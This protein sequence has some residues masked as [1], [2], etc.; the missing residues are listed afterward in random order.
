MGTPE[1]NGQNLGL[2][3]ETIDVER[4]R[5]AEGLAEEIRRQA[6]IGRMHGKFSPLIR[7]RNEAG[8][9]ERLDNGGINQNQ[10]EKEVLGALIAGSADGRTGYDS[11]RW[12]GNKLG[13]W[14][15]NH[16]YNWSWEADGEYFDSTEVEKRW[17]GLSERESRDYFELQPLQGENVGLSRIYYA[18]SQSAASAMETRRNIDQF[19]VVVPNQL[20][21]K[22]WEAV[23]T[24]PEL[25]LALVKTVYPGSGTSWTDKEILEAIKV[26]ELGNEL[27]DEKT[28]ALIRSASVIE[29][30][31]PL[32]GVYMVDG[33]RHNLAEVSDK[34]AFLREA[35]VPVPGVKAVEAPMATE[36]KLPEIKVDK[37]RLIDSRNRDEMQFLAAAAKLLSGYQEVGQLP[38]KIKEPGIE[39]EA[40]VIE[41]RNLREIVYHLEPE[42]QGKVLLAALGEEEQGSSLTEQFDRELDKLLLSW[43]VDLTKR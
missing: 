2:D 34:M 40:F 17:Y 30:R 10:T 1:K 42:L 38:E 29:R 16:G 41:M 12:F 27:P 39:R 26:W 22:I 21:G 4:Q 24:D 15:R 19:S 33:R 25:P 3:G 7:V 5:K 14:S 23:G 35:Y 8:E 11:V 31:A 36:R 18:F 13:D 43:G 28:L 9:L 6:V 37:A 20:A 32:M